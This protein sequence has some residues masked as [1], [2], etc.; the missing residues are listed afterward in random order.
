LEDA[1]YEVF[2]S[3]RGRP[4]VS[5]D[6]GEIDIFLIDKAL[7]D[8]DGIEVCRHL[9]TH[10]PA[11]HLPIVMMSTNMK[12]ASEALNAGAT[13]CLEKAFGILQLL[14]VLSKCVNRQSEDL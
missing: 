4:L 6:F 2:L 13:V 1:G 7:P 8:V 9:R 14:A 12:K 11:K 3:H 10:Q 5:N